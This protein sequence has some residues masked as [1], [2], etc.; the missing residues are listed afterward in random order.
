MLS[1][2]VSVIIPTYNRAHLVQ[3]AVESVLNQTYQDFE[4]IVIDDGSTDN[5]KEVLAVYKDKLAYIYQENRGRSSARNHGI[6][7]AQGEYIAFLDSDD[8]WFPDKLE[9]QV[10]ILEYAP[11][12]VV[13]VHG[14]KCMVDKNLQPVAGWELKLRRLYA[15]AEKG[16]ETYENYLQ[17]T[18]IFTSTILLRKTALLEINGY[19]VSIQGRED[20][21]LYLRLLLQDYCF[22]F[23]SEPALIKYRCH[24]N[25]TNEVSSNY[26]Y[27]QVYEKHLNECLKLAVPDKIA[28]AKKLLYQALAKTH[29]RLRN[30]HQSRIYWQNAFIKDWE[31][32]FTISFWKQYFGSWVRQVI[33]DFNN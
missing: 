11:S 20:L 4:L 12:D 27:L 7:I 23:I 14:Y 30:Y 28:E 6:K 13:L 8:V 2:K 18:C 31:T 25:N 16:E 15:Q 19:D 29:Y 17:S 1:P 26:S 10:P 21:D 22:A 32:A 3:D 9:R 33:L 24:E 5:T